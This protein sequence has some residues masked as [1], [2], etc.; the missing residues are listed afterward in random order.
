MG[1]YIIPVGAGVSVCAYLSRR[2]YFCSW[3]CAYE[4]GWVSCY[5]YIYGMFAYLHIRLFVGIVC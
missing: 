1:S 2:G 3:A 5:I 4:S